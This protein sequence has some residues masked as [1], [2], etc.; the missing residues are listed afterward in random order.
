MSQACPT[1]QSAVTLQPQK[2]PV[3]SA[4]QVWPAMLLDEHTAH[5]PPVSPH[6]AFVVPGWHFIV[7][8]Q[9]TLLHG[10]LG[11]EQ[12]VVHTLPVHAW[13]GGQSLATLQAM[14]VP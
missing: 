8:S 2:P 7:P 4:V 14:H 1:E 12:L 11:S 13:P 9:H 10:E 3:A 6:S 5:A